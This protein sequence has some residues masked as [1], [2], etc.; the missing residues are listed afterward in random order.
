MTT[1][2]IRRSRVAATLG[3]VFAATLWPSPSSLAA[4]DPAVDAQ[5]LIYEINLARWNPV[6][7]SL[8][9]GFS[10]PV[11]PSAPPL[12][13]NA[14]LTS[15]AVFKANE[16]AA[17]SYFAHQSQ[18]TGMWPNELARSFGF[19]LP[20]NWPDDANFIESLHSGSNNPY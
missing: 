4:P 17:Y 1:H 13:P 16:M 15:S 20:A 5:Q 3:I 12:A 10:M 9:S 6:L 14:A 11:V 18:V 7:F 19:P 8:E 2:R